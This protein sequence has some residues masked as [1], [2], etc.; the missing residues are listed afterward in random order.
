MVLLIFL[1][2][3]QKK[4]RESMVKQLKVDLRILEFMFITNQLV[5]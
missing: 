4:L 1:S 5:L 3:M 2:G